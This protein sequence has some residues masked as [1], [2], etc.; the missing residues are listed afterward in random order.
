[1]KKPTLVVSKKPNGKY[2]LIQ[3]RSFDCQQFITRKYGIG[4]I[5]EFAAGKNSA[6]RLGSADS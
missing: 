5:K 1:M 6:A 3:Y 2:Q 4:F